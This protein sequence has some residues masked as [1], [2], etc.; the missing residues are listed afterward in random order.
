M[1][2]LTIILFPLCVLSVYNQ[3]QKPDYFCYAP[4]PC[5]KFTGQTCSIS[6]SFQLNLSQL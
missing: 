3:N 2:V 4:E 6:Q 5:K 1:L